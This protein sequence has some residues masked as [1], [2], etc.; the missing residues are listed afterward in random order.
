MPVEFALLVRQPKE[1]NSAESDADFLVDFT[2]DA[3]ILD[4]VHLRLRLEELLGCPVDV[5]PV[6]GLKARD[7]HLI[8]DSIP[9]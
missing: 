5:V 8:E 1:L 6:G 9:V 3:S 2:A 4:V 7:V